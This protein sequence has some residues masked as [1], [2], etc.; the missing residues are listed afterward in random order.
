MADD[1][2]QAPEVEGASEQVKRRARRLLELEFGKTYDFDDPTHEWR[3]LS[4]ENDK[5]SR[6]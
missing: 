2:Q 6:S 3:R 5:E 4:I 1:Q